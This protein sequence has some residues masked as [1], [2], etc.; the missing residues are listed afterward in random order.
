MDEAVRRHFSR[1]DCWSCGDADV[2]TMLFLSQSVCD[3]S[4]DCHC[5]KIKHTHSS[6]QT[7]STSL[8]K[9]RGTR[10]CGHFRLSP[11][12]VAPLDR[13]ARGHNH[14][15]WTLPQD[16]TRSFQSKTQT[17][18]NTSSSHGFVTKLFMLHG[19][20]VQ[21]PLGDFTREPEQL[22]G[23]NLDTPRTAH[24]TRYRSKIHGEE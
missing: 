11:Q 16:R 3:E 5:R 4:P 12:Q 7:Q 14:G 15:D 19:R 23:T 8:H 22:S 21:D 6:L 2:D 18:V 20:C 17:N 9:Q 24:G 10:S 1:I 13:A